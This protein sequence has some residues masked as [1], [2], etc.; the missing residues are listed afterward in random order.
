MASS[1]GRRWGA[2]LGV[3]LLAIAL[4]LAGSY[5]W[6]DQERMELTD[7]ARQ[8]VAGSFVRL[9]DGVVHYQLAG[10]PS[11]HTVVLVHGFSVPYFIWDPTFDA[12]VASGMRVLRYDLYG[13]GWSDRPAVAYDADLFD[14][15]LRELLDAL[16]IHDP[17]DLAGLSMGG[18]V[19]VRFADR[20][21]ERVR[22][23]ALVDPAYHGPTRLGGW[24]RTPLVGEYFMDVAVAP[25]MPAGQLDDFEHPEGHADYLDRYRVQMRYRGFRRAILSTLRSWERDPDMRE[26]YARVGASKLPV[27]LV[28]GRDDHSVPFAVSDDVRKAMPQVEFHPIDGAGHIPPYENPGVFVPIFE[29][30]LR[31][32]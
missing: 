8:G 16:G 28:W 7:A 9:A 3:V 14:C 23:L 21:P 15:Q 27:L 5:V 13:R 25:S 10:P 26:A 19:A 29:A 18:A 31:A 17:I 32:R 24:L 11:E 1:R 4:A 2:R 6:R 20:H 30:F 12:L 22:S